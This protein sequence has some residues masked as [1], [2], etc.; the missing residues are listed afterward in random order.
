MV[1][2]ICVCL[3]LEYTKCRCADVNNP[4]GSLCRSEPLLTLLAFANPFGRVTFVPMWVC[5]LA[6]RVVANKHRTVSHLSNSYPANPGLCFKCVLTEERCAVC[7]CFFNVL[8]Y[9]LGVVF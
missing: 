3:N 6:V 4:T 2:V 8:D 7:V 1:V 5:L 9:F